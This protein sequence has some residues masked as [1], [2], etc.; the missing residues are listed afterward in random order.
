M[1]DY[2]KYIDEVINRL[3]AYD[4]NSE[5][6]DTEIDSLIELSGDLIRVLTEKN[7]TSYIMNKIKH[8]PEFLKELKSF[9]HPV[10]KRRSFETQRQ[11]LYNCLTYS[12]Y[13]KNYLS[14]EDN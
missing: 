9:D 11:T 8:I 10:I 2:R 12:T 1:D 13:R 14:L 6:I 5:N 4:L 7:T 3:K